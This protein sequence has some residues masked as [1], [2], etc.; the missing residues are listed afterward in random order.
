MLQYFLR[1]TRD[2]VFENN[3][4]PQLL[5]LCNTEDM[6]QN[7][8]RTLHKH[9]THLEIVFI[10]K[11]RGSHIIGNV[12]Y[13]TKEGDVLAFNQ[14]VIHDEMAALGS[15]MIVYCCGIKDL[16]LKGKEKNILFDTSSPAVI[17]SGDKKLL[18]EKTLDIMFQHIREKKQNANE[19][20]Q[21]LLASLLVT[22][23]Q[24][25]HK[26]MKSL[27]YQRIT[28]SEQIKDYIDQ[29]YWDDLTLENLAERFNMSPFYMAHLFKQ[30]TTFSPIQYM[31]R[32]RIGEAQSLL[33]NTN[34]S[35]S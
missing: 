8:P 33:I 12:Q 20:C 7:F 26:E 21:Y 25:P 32:R 13:E 31:I 30:E 6:Q 27:P 24:L 35:I 18:I 17:P 22:I 29:Y 9:D 5:Y 28:L 23:L 19:V 2:S 3:R 34:K 15:G 10:V 4:L 14:G 1:E 16:K 11:G